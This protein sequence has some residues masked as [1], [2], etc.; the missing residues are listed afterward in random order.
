M[1]PLEYYGLVVYLARTKH[2][3]LQEAGVQLELDDLVQE[4]FLGLLDALRRFDA[5]RGVSFSTFAY[6]RIAGAI[7]DYLRRQDFVS[8]GERKELKRIDAARD[9]LAQSLGREPRVRELADTLAISEDRI[10]HSANR[11]PRLEPENWDR[12][13]VRATTPPTQEHTLLAQDVDHC[14]RLALEPLERQVLV[15]RISEEFTL[16]MTSEILG[17]PLQ[18]IFNIEQRAKRKMKDCM[19][20]QGW[21]LSDTGT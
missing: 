12:S 11:A 4:G 6:P 7:D 13:E 8:Q 3:N 16:K 1:D 17:K 2:A 18:T 19:V 9:L 20:G 15:L 14:M 5:N 21:D 10:L